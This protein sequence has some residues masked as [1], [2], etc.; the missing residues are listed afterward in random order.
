MIRFV[1]L[2]ALALLVTTAY[3]Q[4]SAT[5]APNE[6]RATPAYCMLVERHVKVQAKL[7]S[8]LAEYSGKWPAAKQLQAEFDALNLEMKR[9]GEMDP[10][11]MP[12]LTS[13]IGSLILRKT[14]LIG[15]IRILLEEESAQW[16]PLKEKQR[17]LELLNKE[18]EK[19]LS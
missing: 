10:S 18:I 19:I 9:I 7:E 17:E 6:F 11:M 4:Q 14:A 13:G 1:S 15:E 8:T 12:R 16:P 3:G 5:P 2:L